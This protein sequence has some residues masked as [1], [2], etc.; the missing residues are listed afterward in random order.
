MSKVSKILKRFRQKISDPDGRERAILDGKKPAVRNRR[1]SVLFFTI[2][3]AAS[4]YVN[5]TL[6]DLLA[7]A[8]YDH[9]DLA[10]YSFRNTEQ[11]IDFHDEY[12][13]PQGL[14][15]G[16]LREP[17][18]ISPRKKFKTVVQVRDP[19]DVITSFYFSFVYSHRAP[20]HEERR[21]KFEAARKELSLRGIDDYARNLETP[22]LKTLNRY[23]EEFFKRDD[24]LIVHYEDMVNNFPG[25][26]NRIVDYLELPDNRRTRRAIDAIKAAA[27]FDVEREDVFKHKRQVTPGDH[28]RKLQPETIAVMN[29][30]FDSY[31]RTMS[32]TGNMP[33]TYRLPKTSWSDAEAA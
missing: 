20:E 27:N 12:F 17:I 32:A 7:S 23:A 25:W 22:T 2:H 21:K 14:Y 6:R 19:R 3:K 33:A 28:L 13:H 5:Q 24:V 29:R 16:A 9:V 26:L 30:A 4:T 18:A 10:G 15:Y 1:S 8:R 31:F 11:K